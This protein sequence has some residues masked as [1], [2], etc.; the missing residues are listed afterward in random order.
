MWDEAA[1]RWQP[2]DAAPPPLPEALAAA[3]GLTG[4]EGL[5]AVLHNR[6]SFLSGALEGLTETGCAFITDQGGAT[7]PFGAQAPVLL[8]LLNAGTG[9]AVN[10]TAQVCGVQRRAGRWQFELRWEGRPQI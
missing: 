8:N 9:Q 4:A 2:M 5:S 1:G 6:R 3:S 7:P 10:V